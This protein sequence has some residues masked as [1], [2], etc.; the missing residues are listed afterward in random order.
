MKPRKR[1]MNPRS[2][3]NLRRG[4]PGNRGRA[5]G[6][7]WKDLIIEYG[8]QYS[9]VD[10]NRTWR[11]VVVAAA[12]LQAANGNAAILREL[13]ARSEPIPQVI[14]AKVTLDNAVDIVVHEDSTGDAATS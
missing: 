1:K 9:T 2:L 8:D 13:M 7:T 11:E 10:P 12:Y 3:A 5:P 4:N 6:K 14:D